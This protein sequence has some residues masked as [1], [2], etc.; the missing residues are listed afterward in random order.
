MRKGRVSWILYMGTYPP[1]ECGIATF[2]RDLTKAVG[3]K[4]SPGVAS[5]I[6]AMNRNST[7]IYNYP[8]EVIMQISDSNKE[9]Y[10]RA[11]EEINGIEAIKL[12]NIQHE[13]GIFGGKD[14]DY[15]LDFLGRVNKPVIVTFHTVLPKPNEHLRNVVRK[16][17][18]KSACIIVMANKAIEIL[19]GDYGIKSDIFMIPHG[20]P[21]VPLTSSSGEKSK[22]GCKGR[23]VLSSFGLISGNKGYEHV[24][25]ALP[26]V[27][28]K[29]PSL[30]YL[31][32]GQTHPVVRKNEGE[33]YRL[34]LE[35]RIR[36]LGLQKHVKF[37]N[38]YLRL[39][40]ITK[41][42]RATDV[43]IS[44]GI[45]PNQIVSGTLS[46]AMG[47]GRPV[48][49]TPFLHAK[50]SIGGR[51]GIL[52]DFNSPKSFEDGIIK[53][54]SD[55]EAA[56]GMGRNSYYYTRHMTW[57]N[58]ALSYMEVFSKYASMP[59]ARKAIPRIDLKHLANLTDNFGI[60]QF[61]NNTEP[62]VSSGYTL[63]D[64][65][66]ALIAACMHHNL[67]NDSSN[68]KLI[69]IYTGFIENVQQNGG[70][71]YNYVDSSRKVNLEH[72]SDDPHGRALWALGFLISTTTV[73]PEIKEKAE[74]IFANAIN[75]LKEMKS[76]R[77]IAFSILGLCFYN[78]TRF[79]PENVSMI[80]QLADSLE[81]LY[82]RNSAG[83]WKWF[84][85][86]LTYSNSKLSEALFCAYTAT[87]EKKYLYAAEESLNF[88]INATFE[89]GMLLPVGND[90]W[91]LHNGSKAD[92][93]QQ[94]VD[95]AS[96][97]QTL[98][99]AANVTKN[100]CYIE[101]A[102]AAFEWFLGNNSLKQVV[103]DETTG[104][105]HDGIGKSC[106]NLNQGAESTIE[107]LIARLSLM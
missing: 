95:A 24:I 60:I 98:L 4:F 99:V 36:A 77:A 19:A 75:P 27:I 68:L 40:E 71:L 96:M 6:L 14:G 59:E 13:F 7:N 82:R 48:V 66:R 76:P 49:S 88:L 50:E 52:V 92:F 53:L 91:Y 31:I 26:E 21:T 70:R 33:R 20:I 54:V 81:Y 94:P 22:I 79:S 100:N 29:F 45:N 8:K 83:E 43:Y 35:S 104:G 32:I 10:A 17:S 63:D 90:G 16:I 55:L 30:V 58:V 87:K 80:R 65:A 62:D 38:K 9:E 64:N 39:G 61:A 42:L 107:Y 47:C 103:Y 69:S 5:K 86:Y 74:R 101:K 41:Y 28:K 46:Y 57:P 51:N 97:V 44:S 93:D 56:A 25:E 37:Y 34:F 84:E 72:W 15:L 89:N 67:F 78:K 73:P 18:E 102:L 23:I 105:C 3:R 12:I 1:R 85:K 106:I 2:T 11:A